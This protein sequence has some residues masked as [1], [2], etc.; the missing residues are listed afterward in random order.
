MTDRPVPEGWTTRER[1][2]P[3]GAPTFVCEEMLSRALEALANA[4]D[5]L[6]SEGDN[7]KAYEDF[8]YRF[9]RPTWRPIAA[10]DLSA[11]IVYLY[12]V[13]GCLG[14]ES[15]QTT[16]PYEPRMG[17]AVIEFGQLGW[18]PSVAR[19]RTWT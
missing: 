3:I 8:C 19:P 4:T 16:T 14:Y 12:A 6:D 18:R 11:C 17:K 7:A 15:P 1:L 13:L 9:D 2:Y 5:G 10:D